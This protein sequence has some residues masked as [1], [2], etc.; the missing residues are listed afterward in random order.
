M[1]NS[2]QFTPPKARQLNSYIKDIAKIHAEGSDFGQYVDFTIQRIYGGFNN[3]LYK[4]ESANGAF[5]CKLCVEDIRQRV[6]FLGEKNIG[7]MQSA[8]LGLSEILVTIALAHF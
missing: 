1:G 5:A 2:D 7:G 8:I 3:A 4:I 6:L